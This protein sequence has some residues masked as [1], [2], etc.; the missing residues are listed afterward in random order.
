MR[1]T[2]TQGLAEIFG[3]SVATALAP[4]RLASTGTPVT[5]SSPLPLTPS[6][7]GAGPS[8]LDPA[9][10]PLLRQMREHFDKANAALTQGNLALYAEEIKR[11]QAVLDK[12]EKIRK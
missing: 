2:L 8:S 12:I 9:L 10:V 4:D 6:A 5:G 11:A 1:E 3:A 7:A